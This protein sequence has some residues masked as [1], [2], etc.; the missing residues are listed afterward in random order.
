MSDEKRRGFPERY[1]EPTIWKPDFNLVKEVQEL[2]G[3]VRVL[4]ERLEKSQ[5]DSAR[6]DKLCIYV[7]TT[8][9]RDVWSG[10]ENTDYRAGYEQAFKHI[11]E[12]MKTLGIFEE[13]QS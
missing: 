4:E 9:Y 8:L 6:L 2:R 7:K 11:E 5:A 12:R 3:Y 13:K 1:E 10:N